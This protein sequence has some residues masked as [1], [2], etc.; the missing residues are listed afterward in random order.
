MFQDFFY[1]TAKVLVKY[2][3]SINEKNSYGETALHLAAANYHQKIVELL[4]SVGANP[5]AEND[6]RLKPIDVVP[7][8]DPVTKQVYFYPKLTIVGW[9]Y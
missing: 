7:E 5:F 3:V 8:S 2:R 6:V 4:L 9:I 1:A